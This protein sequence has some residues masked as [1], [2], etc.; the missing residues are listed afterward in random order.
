MKPSLSDAL[1]V[2][3]GGGA[4]ATLRAALTA[5][6]PTPAPGAAP[7][8]SAL[9]AL[10]VTV[11]AINC[12]GAFLLGAL[13]GFLSNRPD[14]ASTRSLRLALGTGV[15]GGFT[16]YSSFALAV[17]QFGLAGQWLTGA[18]YLVLSLVGGYLLAW[19]GLV[20]GKKS[21]N[22]HRPATAQPGGT[23]Q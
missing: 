17:A 1:L 3:C 20:W 19:V 13:T 14:T 10:P 7:G 11:L 22:G 5:L 9:G 23:P 2:F 15:L 12:V 8:G 6:F 4:G 16:T 21:G 18:L